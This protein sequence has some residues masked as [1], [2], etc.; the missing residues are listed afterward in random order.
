MKTLQWLLAGVVVGVIVVAFRDIERNTWLA[1][2]L[3]E[4]DDI[5]EEEPFLGYDGMDQETLLGWI[6]DADPDEHTLEKMTR[7][8]EENQHR[9]PVLDALQELLG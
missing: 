5:S 9:Q 3:A 6:V 7:Y 8:E 1:P 4:P 2:W